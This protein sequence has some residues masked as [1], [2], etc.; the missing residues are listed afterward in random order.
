M[1]M[2]R[3][4][5]ATKERC[6]FTEVVLSETRTDSFQGEASTIESKLLKAV[7]EIINFQLIYLTQ[8]SLGI[9]SYALIQSKKNIYYLCI[10]ILALAKP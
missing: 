5:G 1:L 6:G 8:H 2:H 7:C 10:H 3:L 4:T 9:S